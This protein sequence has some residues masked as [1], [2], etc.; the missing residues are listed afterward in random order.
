MKKLVDKFTPSKMKT[1]IMSKKYEAVRPWLIALT[2][3]SS[4]HNIV[5]ALG[6]DDPVPLWKQ[7][8]FNVLTII[9]WVCIIYSKCKQIE[10]VKVGMIVMQ[11]RFTLGL[12]FIDDVLNR[13]NPVE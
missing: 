9:S 5:I 1:F 11:M 3:S 2:I 4:L 8:I 6:M 7:I 10:A 12:F 13:N